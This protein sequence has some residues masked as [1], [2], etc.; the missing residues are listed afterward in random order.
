MAR[1]LL[2]KFF[3]ETRRNSTLLPYFPNGRRLIRDDTTHF[4]RRKLL[5]TSH[6]VAIVHVPVAHSERPLS[7]N[8]L[9]VLP[10]ASWRDVHHVRDHATR[11]NRAGVFQNPGLPIIG[12]VSPG[13]PAS[14]PASNRGARSDTRSFRPDTNPRIRAGWSVKPLCEATGIRRDCWPT[15]R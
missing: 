10:G 3:G 15:M 6:H 13:N 2:W 1:S 14:A 9:H 4:C 11:G 7:Q 12:K 8:A 5:D